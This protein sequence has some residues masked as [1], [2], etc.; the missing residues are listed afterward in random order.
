V[1]QITF[2]A[3]THYADDVRSGRQIMGGVPVRP[4]PDRPEDRPR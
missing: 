1:A 3:I 2:E 4:A